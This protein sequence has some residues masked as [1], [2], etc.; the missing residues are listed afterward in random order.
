MTVERESEKACDARHTAE[1]VPLET[2]Q[3]QLGEYW[4][5]RHTRYAGNAP[6]LDSSAATFI[7]LCF[8]CTDAEDEEAVPREC[9]MA[10]VALSDLEAGVNQVR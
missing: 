10:L 6:Y 8:G 7:S 2:A 5:N 3:K 1:S 9:N 4:L